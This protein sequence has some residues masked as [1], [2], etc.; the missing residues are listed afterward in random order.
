MMKGT[1]NPMRH[2]TVENVTYAIGNVLGYEE[3]ISTRLCGAVD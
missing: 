2:M 3:N 1:W